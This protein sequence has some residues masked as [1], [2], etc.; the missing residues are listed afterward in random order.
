MGADLALGDLGHAV[1]SVIS[2]IGVTAD[3]IPPLLGLRG[4]GAE[5]GLI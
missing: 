5:N 2:A 3:H 1:L 4:W